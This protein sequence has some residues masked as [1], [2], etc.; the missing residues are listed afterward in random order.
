MFYLNHFLTAA[1]L[2]IVPVIVL[3]VGFKFYV[4]NPSNRTEAGL[5]NVWVETE[6][7]NDDQ[8]KIVTKYSIHKWCYL[9]IVKHHTNL[10]FLNN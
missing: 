10:D 6:S 1:I 5:F 8:T 4:L 7:I 3:I 9:R 2:L